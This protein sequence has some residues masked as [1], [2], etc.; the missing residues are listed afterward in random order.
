MDQSNKE[1][2]ISDVKRLLGR[3]A[4]D[5]A[6][7][8]LKEVEIEYGDLLLYLIRLADKAGVDLM[9]GA[10]R[11]MDRRARVMPRPADQSR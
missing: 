3:F 6:D 5:R 1:V 8:P 11:A 10:N 2:T 7:R 9:T 4:A